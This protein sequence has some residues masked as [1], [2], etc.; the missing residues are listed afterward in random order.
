MS[1][2]AAPCVPTVVLVGGFLGA[3]KTTRL[4]AAVKALNK[5]NLRSALIV[6]IRAIHWSILSSRQFKELLIER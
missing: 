1:T 6:T 3:G 2:K 5:L 4:L